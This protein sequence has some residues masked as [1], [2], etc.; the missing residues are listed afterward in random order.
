MKANR[1]FKLD[2]LEECIGAGAGAGADGQQEAARAATAVAAT[3]NLTVFMLFGQ[4]L[5]WL[6][7]CVK[8]K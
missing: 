4:L 6:P 1:A 3:R 8:R 5:V 7:P 2:Y